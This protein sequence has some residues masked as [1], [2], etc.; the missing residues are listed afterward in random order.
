L[1]ANVAIFTDSQSAI[2][3][4]QSGTL[5]QKVQLTISVWSRLIALFPASESRTCTIQY[6]YIPAH[7]GI[8]G[9]EV[10]DILAA[11]GAKMKQTLLP[12]QSLY[13]PTNHNEKRESPMA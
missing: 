6:V 7:C 9:N 8:P 3:S 10:A 11:E 12:F 5:R 4:L 1:P 2:R 13:R